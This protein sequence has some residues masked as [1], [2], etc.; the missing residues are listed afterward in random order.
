MKLLMI[1]GLGSAK[2]L[3]SG[4]RGAF[5]NTLEEFHQYWDRIDIIAPKTY[6]HETTTK[7]LFGNVYVHISSWPLIFH[8]IWFLKKAIELHKEQKFDLVTV[9]EFPP[10][11]NGIAARLLWQRIKVPY[12][13]EVH[14]IPGYPR[15]GS[16]KEEIYRSLA[17]VF[18]EWDAKYARAVRVVNQSQVPNFLIEAG[19]PK[20]KINY[21]PSLYIDLDIFRPMNLAKE[22]DLIFVGRLEKNKGIN[23]FLEA[24]R[25]L[26][27]QTPKIKC[28]IVGD[29]PLK[30]SLK[31]KIKSLKLDNNVTFYGWAKDQKEIAQLLNKSRILVMLSYNEGGPRVVVEAM[32]CGLPVLATPVGMVPEL[33]KDSSA[34]KMVSWD[35]E[36]VAKK[37]EEMLVNY[38]IYKDSGIK[39]AQRFEKKDMIK[40]YA[41]KLIDFCK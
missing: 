31:F 1:T 5:S 10:F 6:N 30:E 35:P 19:V 8:P 13:L 38:E 12:I 14:H 23:L 17:K 33:V 39:I 21:I 15:A 18:M 28:L 34:G 41:E 22:Y 20:G 27:H 25:N 40:K 29:G 2:D 4:R 26:K 3:A 9:Q 24:I 32:A 11:Y 16:V 7:V 36:D 37:A